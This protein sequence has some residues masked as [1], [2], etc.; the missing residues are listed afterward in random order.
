MNSESCPAGPTGVEVDMDGRK[1]WFSQAPGSLEALLEH[2]A[3]RSLQTRRVVEALH[4]D[5]MR[6]H[7]EKATQ[8]VTQFQQL[9]VTT[10]SLDEIQARRLHEALAHADQL[11]QQV[12]S[13]SLVMLINEWRPA[14][15]LWQAIVP[16]LREL[17]M[18]IW[19][20]EELRDAQGPQGEELWQALRRHLEEVEV[21]F[22]RIEWMF[23]ESENRWGL[24]EAVNLSEQM[25]NALG[26]WLEGLSQHL[27]RMGEHLRA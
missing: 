20:L 9:K 11:R 25:E 19:S 5:G 22:S 2:L 18:E 1:L 3:R 17:L 8:V 27:A 6:V 10:A 13:V 16:L 12:R 7:P 15:D 26:R 24:M 23:L 4:V 14:R 21:H